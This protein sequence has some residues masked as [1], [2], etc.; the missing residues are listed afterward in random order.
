MADF[1]AIYSTLGR[2]WSTGMWPCSVPVA[3]TPHRDKCTNVIYHNL[4]FL[5]RHRL[6]YIIY[7]HLVHKIQL[8]H[9]IEQFTQCRK[10]WRNRWR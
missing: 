5:L 10:I 6:L 1:R 2:L 3:G 8:Y 7:S 4:F 9:S